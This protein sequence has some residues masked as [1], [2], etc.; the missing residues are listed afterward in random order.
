MAIDGTWS[1]V[2]DSPLGEQKSSLD[3]RSD[4]ETLIGTGTGPNGP[5]EI[6][7]GRLEGNSLSW[8]L[9]VVTPFP[10][11]LEFAG[12]FSGDKISGKVKAGFVGS[13]PFIGVRA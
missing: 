13:F 10:M 1:V 11:T 12:E 8:K 9:D 6:K 4:G 2:V 7:Q 5:V 3:L